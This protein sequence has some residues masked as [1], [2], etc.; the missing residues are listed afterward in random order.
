MKKVLE[1]KKRQDDSQMGFRKGR[2]TADAIYI[3]SKAVEME[4]K[5]NGG[6]V[7]AFFA[8]M[9]VDFDKVKRK[10][11]WAMM[12]KLGIADKVREMVEEVYEET[13]SVLRVGNRQVGGFETYKRVRQG[14]PLSP[15]LFNVVMSDPE[16]E[17]SKVQEGGI[18]LGK[19]KLWTVSYAD[20]IVLL[21][22]DAGGLKQMLKR[23]RRWLK[24]RD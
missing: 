7:Y 4:L 10:E 24:K 17:M 3:V 14:C 6:K 11:I 9:R 20:D 22:T 8:D 5:K 13:R 12:R 21:A 19:K 16:K 23:F 1:G 18:I 15:T 2:G